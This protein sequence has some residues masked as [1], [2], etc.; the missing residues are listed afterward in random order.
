MTSYIV[1]YKPDPGQNSQTPG[2]TGWQQLDKT[3]DA[4]SDNAAVRAAAAD[5]RKPGY[6]VGIP[7]RSFDPVRIEFEAQPRVKVVKT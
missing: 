3:F 5:W 1:L 2:S 6:Y 7:A 4:T